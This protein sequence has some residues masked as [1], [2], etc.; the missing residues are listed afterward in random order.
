[1]RAM[2]F[3]AGLCVV[4][5][6]ASAGPDYKPA[7]LSNGNLILTNGCVYAPHASGQAQVWSLL[8]TQAG[9][10][11]G[12]A[13]TLR[14]Q[15]APVASSYASVPPIP[16]AQPSPVYTAPVHTSRASLHQAPV[17]ADEPRYLLGVYR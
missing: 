15:S 10:P 8:Y 6:A 9:T 13:L 14:T 2:M 7:S 11:A 1:M 5:S 3:A 4:A 12:C 16:V 17:P